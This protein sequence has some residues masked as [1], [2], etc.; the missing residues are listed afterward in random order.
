[1]LLLYPNPSKYLCMNENI[2]LSGGEAKEEELYSIRRR[3]LFL[4]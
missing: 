2:E 3:G 1:M 4:V